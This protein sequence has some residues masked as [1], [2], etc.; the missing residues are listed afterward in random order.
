MPRQIERHQ[1]K[2]R[3]QRRET[4]EA[5]RVVQPAVDREDR[6][7]IDGYR[8]RRWIVEQM[9]GEQTTTSA[10]LR[11]SAVRM[12]SPRSE[13]DASSSLSRNT[14]FNRRGRPARCWRKRPGTRYR[15]S[16]RCNQAAQRSSAW[17]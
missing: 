4:V 10:S 2:V 14:G 6:L 11:A 17:L 9:P 5:R 12:E 13:D 7:T 1:V 15:S 3:E 16:D 8:C